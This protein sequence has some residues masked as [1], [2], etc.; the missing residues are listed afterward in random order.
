MLKN[1][2]FWGSDLHVATPFIPPFGR[3]SKSFMIGLYWIREFVYWVTSF[4]NNLLL[5]VW[6]N[7]LSEFWTWDCA[8]VGL[9]KGI[10]YRFRPVVEEAFA[11]VWVWVTW[12]TTQLHYS[13][14][15]IDSTFAMA[16]VNIFG[17]I[18]I[19]AMFLISSS[20]DILKGEGDFLLSISTVS[21]VI[22]PLRSDLNLD[23]DILGTTLIDF[24]FLGAAWSDI[25]PSLTARLRTSFGKTLTCLISFITDLSIMFLN[26]VIIL[27]SE[28]MN[29]TYVALPSKLM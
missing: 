11:Q 3:N 17:F 6:T 2:I 29:M 19:S 10:W 28:E 21:G 25:F 8:V 13:T 9:H 12:R 7:I 20:D 24:F 5:F 4:K 23:P 27:E 15:L 26:Y 1:H 16:V 18:S 22:K 14:Y